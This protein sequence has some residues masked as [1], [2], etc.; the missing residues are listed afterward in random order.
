MEKRPS[1]HESTVRPI[2]EAWAA[3][4]DSSDMDV[5]TALRQS[6]EPLSDDELAEMLGRDSRTIG[7]ECR[8]LAF[9]GLVIR[10]QLPNK[11][12]NKVYRGD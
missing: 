1:G 6:P 5:L 12:I 4:G 2:L 9:R 8:S 3:P 7:Q 10:E 11:M